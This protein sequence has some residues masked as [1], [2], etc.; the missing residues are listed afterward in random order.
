MNAFPIKQQ[1]AASIPLGTEVYYTGNR[2]CPAT[3]GVVTEHRGWNV[4]IKCDEYGTL[5]LPQAM[6][7]KCT[8]ENAT[9]GS[10]LFFGAEY[11]AVKAERIAAFVASVGRS[12]P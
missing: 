7:T 2:C 6:L 10:C 3:F 8:T 4:G 9:H 12:K 5:W 1:V 11:R